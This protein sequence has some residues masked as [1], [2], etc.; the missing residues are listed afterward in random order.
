MAHNLMRLAGPLLGGLWVTTSVAAAKPAIR[1]EHRTVLTSPPD[2]H[3]SQSRAALIPGNP[4]RVLL[5]TQQIEKSGSH[6]YRDLFM[7]ETRD[8]AQTWTRPERIESLRRARMPEGHDLVM[9]DVCPQWH[10]ATRVVLAT[11][12]TFGFDG[13]VKENRAFERVSYA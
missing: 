13:G 3:W 7:V 4:A 1:I 6:G 9:G 10:A 11:G 8:G 12:K 2:L 5:T